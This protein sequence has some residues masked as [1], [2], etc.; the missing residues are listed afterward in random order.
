MT[1]AAARFTT[2]PRILL[3]ADEEHVVRALTYVLE[4]EGFDVRAARDG[5]SA[6]DAAKG[7]LPDVILLEVEMSDSGGLETLACI[8]EQETLKGTPV[9]LMCSQSK[10]R[11][12]VAGLERGAD[13]FI[14]KPFDPRE[15]L[16]RIRAQIR[17]RNLQDQVLRAERWRVLV[18]TAGGVAHEMSQPLTAVMGNL[19]LLLMRLS[20]EDPVRATILRVFENGERAVELLRKLQRIESYELKSY[21][22]TAGILDIE[23]SSKIND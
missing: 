7:F 12:V 5:S 9:L 10:P 21:P 16:A 23:R 13:D 15:V 14:T 6:L 19:E 20:T 18:E 17:I 8:R 22:G 1:P 11:D 2:R 3:V 4:R